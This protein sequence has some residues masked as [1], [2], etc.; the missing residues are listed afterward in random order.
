L[1]WMYEVGRSA[2]GT[3]ERWHFLSAD[4]LSL[5][6]LSGQRLPPHSLQGRVTV[7][8]DQSSADTTSISP[9]FM[10]SSWEYTF[11]NNNII[12]YATSVYTVLYYLYHVY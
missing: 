8:V 3:N 4:R 1:I 10:T 6:R 7:L 12:L 9:W 11:N 2:I 5:N